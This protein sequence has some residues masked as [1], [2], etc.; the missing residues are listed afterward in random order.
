MTDES[1]RIRKLYENLI[2]SQ[3]HIFPASGKIKIRLLHAEL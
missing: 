2:S 1:Q 3:L